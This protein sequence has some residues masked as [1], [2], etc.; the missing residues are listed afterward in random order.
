M[1]RQECSFF[2][3]KRILVTGHTGFVGSWLCMVLTKYGAD[4]AGISLL[5]ESKSLYCEVEKEL[6]MESHICD[7]RNFEMVQQVMQEIKPEIVMHLAAFGFVKECMTEPIRT[8]SSN[9]MGTVNLLEA[10][11]YVP[12][13]K[14]VLIVSSDKV[15]ENSFGEIKVFTEKDSL[16]GMDIYSSSKTCEDLIAQ[17]YYDSYLKKMGIS[18]NI[19][20]PGNIL[21]GGDYIQSRL[22]PSLLRGFEEHRPIEIRNRDAIRPWQNILDAI[23][24]YLTVIYKTWNSLNPNIGIYNVGPEESGQMSVGEISDYLEGKME[25]NGNVVESMM[26][27]GIRE[28]VYLGLSSEKIFTEFDW[29]P[30]RTMTDTLDEIF[31]FWEK[32]RTENIYHICMEIINSYCKLVQ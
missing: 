13:V 15:Y 20:R 7:L 5:P 9:V 11:R 24:A 23:D 4:V 14:S 12:T 22:I 10:C 6:R 3:N 25:G 8:F 21:G 1:N 26:Q 32:S 19:V 2:K 31:Y 17:S 30:R 18:F 16:G 29:R 28:A 27:L